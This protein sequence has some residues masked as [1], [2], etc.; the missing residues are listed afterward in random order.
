MSIDLTTIKGQ[1]TNAHETNP[2][3][4]KKEIHPGNYIVK[5]NVNFLNNYDNTYN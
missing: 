2:D 1:I 3:E 5:K 4:W